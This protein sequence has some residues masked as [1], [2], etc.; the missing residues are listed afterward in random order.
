MKAVVWEGLRQEIAINSAVSGAFS[1]RGA[2]E[3]AYL[4]QQRATEPM[5]TLIAI[6]SGDRVVA[7]VPAP[8]SNAIVNAP[9]VDGDGVDELLLDGSVQ[10]FGVLVTTARLV[11]LSGKELKTV[12]DFGGVYEG[13][14]VNG[15]SFGIRAGVL[16]AAPPGRDGKRAFRIDVFGAS[17]RPDGR[18][19]AVEE[20]KPL[21]GEKITAVIPLPDAP[22]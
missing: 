8:G 19:P 14:C 22:R 13:G 20:F 2:R 11:R 17:C 5:D 4:L 6:L 3:T 18:Q 21:P 1:K 15:Q 10:T 7:A 12:H 16:H 9:D